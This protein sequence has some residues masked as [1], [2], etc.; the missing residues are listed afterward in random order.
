MAALVPLAAPPQGKWIGATAISRSARAMGQ[1]LDSDL[2]CTISQ[3]LVLRQRHRTRGHSA[4]LRPRRRAAHPPLPTHRCPPTAPTLRSHR[5]RRSRDRHVRTFASSLGQLCDHYPQ[6]HVVVNFFD[7]EVLTQA[8][9][10]QALPH[11]QLEGSSIPGMKTLFWRRVL[12][13]E[14]VASFSFVCAARA[15]RRRPSA[16]PLTRDSLS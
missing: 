3:A 9:M 11:P 8:Q 12:T 13:P 14:R 7:R 16:R 4:S 1:R 5:A 2:S 15:A 10:R 6:L